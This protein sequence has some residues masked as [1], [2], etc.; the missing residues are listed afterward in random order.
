MW[1]YLELRLYIKGNP[2]KD[3]HTAEYFYLRSLIL[4]SIDAF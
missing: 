4:Y 3:S 1:K 2:N